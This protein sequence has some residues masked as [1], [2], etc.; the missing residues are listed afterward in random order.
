M[1]L[2]HLSL[3]WVGIL[4]YKEAPIPEMPMPADLS[5]ADL[6]KKAAADRA[7]DFVQD[8]MRLGLGTGS[9]AAF[10]VRRLGERVRQEGLRVVG[11]P[12]SSRTAELARAEGIRVVTLDQAGWL[13]L[14]IDGADEFDPDLTLIKGGGGAHLQEKVVAAASDRM[15]VISD[16][17]K[18]VARLG[19]FPLPVE[20][21]KF[22]LNST[23]RHIA[24]VLADLGYGGRKITLRQAG[25]QPFVSDEGNY[26]LD[27]H[28]QAISDAPALSGALNQIP[29]LVENGLFINMSDLIIVGH[30]DGSSDLI[31]A[32]PGTLAAMSAPRNRAADP[33]A[34]IKE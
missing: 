33:F 17:A 6:A 21:L 30:D 5:P 28:L 4:A 20:V 8:G 24:R 34:D 3:I 13:D 7:V 9:T 19:A 2:A 27:L 11:V 32:Q 14:T 31:E 1:A 23:E 16:R 18:R 25:D 29:G 12:T 10:M 15:I 26:I 22:G